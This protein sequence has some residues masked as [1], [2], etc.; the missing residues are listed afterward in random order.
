MSPSTHPTPPFAVLPSS[1][2]TRP[3]PTNL[4]LFTTP[5]TL[6]SLAPDC[7]TCAICHETFGEYRPNISFQT[8]TTIQEWAVR[9]EITASPDSSLHLCGHVFG[10]RCLEN[11]LNSR[12]PWHNK[13]PMCRMVWF[14]YGSEGRKVAAPGAG[15]WVESEVVRE[16]TT[17]GLDGADDGGLSNRGRLRRSAGFL[18]QVLE[19]FNMEE[20]SDEVKMSI[21]EVERALERLYSSLEGT[22]E[23]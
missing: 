23:R 3:P 21:E 7:R 17:G 15:T 6:A 22:G 5:L 2:P 18:Q 8:Q 13:C 10:K 19:A 20:G 16:S 12:Q 14:E 4:V 1:T 11:H 9:V